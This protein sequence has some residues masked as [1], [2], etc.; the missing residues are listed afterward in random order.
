[1]K[2]GV[3]RLGCR[4]SESPAF[5]R[6]PSRRITWD[7]RRGFQ[8]LLAV[9]IFRE[10]GGCTLKPTCCWLWRGALVP[11][12][13]CMFL[14]AA[15]PARATTYHLSAEGD[16]AWSGTLP[17]PNPARTD[18][19]WR[20]LRKIWD[21]R[22]RFRPGDEILLRRGDVWNQAPVN[23][24]I[25]IE[26]GRRA[27][28]VLAFDGA[29]GQPI[30]LGAYGE[31]DKPVIDGREMSTTNYSL[32]IPWE[33]NWVTIQDLHLIPGDTT[34]HFI[35]FV[36]AHTDD[37][38]GVSHVKVVRVDF[39]NSLDVPGWFGGH[40]IC[41]DNMVYLDSSPSNVPEPNPGAPCHDVEISHCRFVG[42]GGI[43]AW[44]K[45]DAI[46]VAAPKGGRFWIHDNEF[47]HTNEAIDVAGDSGHVI[48]HNFIVATSQYQGI[49]VHSQFSHVSDTKIRG[50]VIVGAW[51]YAIAVENISDSEISHNTIYS[52]PHPDG[53]GGVRSTWGIWT[54][55]RPRRTTARSRGISSPTTSRGA[56]RTFSGRCRRRTSA[57][58]TRSGTTPT[59]TRPA[60][61]SSLGRR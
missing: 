39:D 4:A 27:P 47:Y 34:Y 45:W 55:T 22:A 48:E 50:N 56:R 16:D 52:V 20:W 51:G 42:I 8:P 58:S 49:K 14:V 60:P 21:E 19:P 57:W 61:R 54:A 33:T 23:P 10:R 7:V 31:G 25:Q 29:P 36:T 28:V 43:S 6:S 18:G 46:N 17:E 15:V 9:R 3:D 1:M 24:L 41:F 12:F 32:I 44:K 2:Y 53:G 35:R 59:G 26:Q 13:L 30:T 38:E 5:L 11:I 40:G 37:T